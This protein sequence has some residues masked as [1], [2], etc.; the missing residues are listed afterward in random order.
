MDG[1]AHGKQRGLPPIL[2]P[3]L[4]ISQSQYGFSEKQNFPQTYRIEP[5]HNPLPAS[6]L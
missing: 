1:R 4:S 3:P 5:L 2:L 6:L